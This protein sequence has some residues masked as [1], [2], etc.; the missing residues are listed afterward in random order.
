[1]RAMALDHFGGVET[2]SL[3]ELPLPKLGPREVLIRVEVAG[4]GEWDPFER[5]GGFASLLGTPAEFPYVLGSEG[6]GVVAARG[7]HVTQFAPGDRVY[8]LNFPNPHGG[9]YAE[10]AAIDQRLVAPIPSH[11]DVLQAGVM[12]GVGITALR[13][14]QDTLALKAGES[15]IVVGASGGIG[16]IAVQLAKFMGARVLAVA[17][18]EDGV[19]LARR[20]GADLAIDGHRDDV[21][22]A[23]RAF[24]ADGLDAALLTAGGAVAERAMEALR[25]G[26]RAAYPSGVEPEPKE[27]AGV[28]LKNF[29]GKPD[30]DIVGRFARWITKGPFEVHVAETFPLT[31]AAAAQQALSKHFLGK[32]ALRVS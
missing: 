27:R 24:G 12:G 1:M 8:A 26:G 15:L 3:H 17:S 5:E 14:L 19:A 4:V 29:D 7:S 18:G 6:A 31:D 21:L 22:T 20:L 25:K 2:M 9:F 13:G 28:Q 16:H 11:L 10:Y 30:A 23:A 32:L